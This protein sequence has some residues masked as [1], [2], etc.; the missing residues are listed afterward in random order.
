MTGT[1]WITATP[2]FA[3]W[4][5]IGGCSSTDP[6]PPVSLRITTITSG[7]N[8]DPDGYLAGIDATSQPVGTNGSVVFTGLVSGFHLVGLSEVAA[9]CGLRENS[10]RLDVSPPLDSPE[11]EWPFRVT[12]FAAPLTGRMPS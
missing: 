10:I 11:L 3:A 8:L 4:L 9:N 5:F 6:G 1:R 12:C 2:I 7:E